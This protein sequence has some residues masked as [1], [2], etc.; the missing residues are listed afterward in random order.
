MIRRPPRSTRT[1]TLF[2]YTT[3]FRSHAGDGTAAE[4]DVH[5]RAHALARRFGGADVGAHRDV[6]ADVAGSARQDRDDRE[7]DRGGPVEEE[8]DQDQKH[9]AG[10]PDRRVLAGEVGAGALLGSAGELVLTVLVRRLMVAL[11]G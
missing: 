4:R 6:H 9:N 10:D 8:A 3:L 2:P 1:A 11:A 7:T 5:R